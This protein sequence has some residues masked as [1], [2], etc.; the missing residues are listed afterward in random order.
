MGATEW[1][2]YRF[3]AEFGEE[4]DSQSQR[5]A[6]GSVAGRDWVWDRDRGLVGDGDR[7]DLLD[8]LDCDGQRS[9]GGYGDSVVLCCY[10]V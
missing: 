10:T 8:V 1:S 5:V 4:S 6:D 9:A 2:D 7:L 3:V